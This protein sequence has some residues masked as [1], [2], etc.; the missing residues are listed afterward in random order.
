MANFLLLGPT[1][2]PKLF[3]LTEKESPA[4]DPQQQGNQTQAV[5]AEATLPPHSQEEA[6]PANPALP[7][8]QSVPAAPSDPQQT[9]ALAAPLD[10]HK[11]AVPA[12]PLFFDQAVP[13]TLNEVSDEFVSEQSEEKVYG[14]GIF[15]NCP[16]ANLS[17]DYLVSLRKFVCS[18]SHLEENIASVNIEQLSSRQLGH[19]VFVHTVKVELS[20]KTARL[21]EPPAVYIKKHLAKNEWLKGNKTRITLAVQ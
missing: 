9:A 11:L 5:S 1:T 18:E 2:L 19:E 21:W 13:A 15:E 14:M 3:I 17:E 6:D 12:E 20:V 10:S 7:D 4:V 16:D 8:E